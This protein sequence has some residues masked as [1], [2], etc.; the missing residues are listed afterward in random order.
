MRATDDR[1]RESSP[2]GIESE[3]DR[4]V[5][6]LLLW[7]FGCGALGLVPHVLAVPGPTGAR[8]DDPRR[9]TTSGE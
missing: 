9:S 2:P 7:P 4:V 5:G 3:L 8:R 1:A 6:T